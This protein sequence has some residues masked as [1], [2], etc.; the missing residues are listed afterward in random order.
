MKGRKGICLN[1]KMPLSVFSSKAAFCR[2]VP[3]DQNAAFVWLPPARE[4]GGGGALG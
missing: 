2:S 4:G 3:R 1:W